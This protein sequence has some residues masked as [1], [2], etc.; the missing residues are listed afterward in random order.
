MR[1]IALT[2]SAFGPY[3][4]QT[5]LDL[6]QLGTGG[7][8]LIT[9]DT[10]AGK[11][12]L[13]DAITFGLYGE[14][15]GENRKPEMLR[16]QYADPATP[17][18]VELTFLCRDK[19]Y[20]VRRN[21]EYQRPAKRGGGVTLQ[22][23]EAQL[24]L[25]DGSVI[26]RGRDVNTKIE[27]ILGLDRDQFSRIA[28]IAQGDFRKL[29]FADTP[30]RQKIFRQLF[31]TGH[32]E[33]L[34]RRIGEEARSLRTACS[35]ARL[36]VNQYIAGLRCPEDS[37]LADT[38]A[39]AQ[40]GQL[41][42]ADTLALA[43]RLLA[44]DTQQKAVLDAKAS[45]LAQKLTQC[46]VQLGQAQETEKMQASLAKALTQQETLAP[47]LAQLE[48]DWLAQNSPAMQ[49]R[50]ETLEKEIHTLE[51]A[52]PQYQ[53][54][55]AQQESCRKLS[56]QVQALQ[57]EQIRREN[58]VQ[59]AQNALA[60]ARKALETLQDADTMLAGLEAKRTALQGQI[61]ALHD[62]QTLL[63]Q[64]K[65][66]HTETLAAQSA[67]VQA[68]Q[69]LAQALEQEK[70]L[71]KAIADEKAALAPLADSIEKREQIR[72]QG[73]EQSDRCRALTQAVEEQLACKA[74]RQT[75]QQA[76]TAYCDAAHI[77]A[78]REQTFQALQKAF[79]DE[80]AGILAQSLI[81]GV[82]CPVCGSIHHPQLAALTQG[83][84]TRDAVDA[85]RQQADQAQRLAQ[86]AS[87]EANR[88]KTLVEVRETALLQQ[89]AQL[90]HWD[91]PLEQA[92]A[93]LSAARTEAEKALAALRESYRCQDQIVQEKSRREEALAQQEQTLEALQPQLETL[94]SQCTQALTQYTAA[95][96]REEHLVT[97][98]AKQAPLLLG[99]DTQGDAAV[100]LQALLLNYSQ[101]DAA[102]QAQQAQQHQR[103]ER[104][105]LLRQTLPQQEQALT[106]AQTGLQAGAQQLA[107][108]TASLA[109]QTAQAESMQKALPLAGRPEAEAQLAAFRTQRDAQIQQRQT[110]LQQREQ[111][112]AQ[113][114][115]LDGQIQHLQQ[116]LK[117]APAVDIEAIT[118]QQADWQQQ[119]NAVEA[120]ARTVYA[121]AEAN[122][123]AR[124]QMAT[125]AEEL[126]QLEQRYT[127]VNALDE[128]TAG[129]ISGKGKVMLETYVQMTY[130]DRILQRANL[131]FMMMSSGQYELVRCRQAENNRNQS[132]L[133]L[134]VIDHY[135]GTRRS[136]KTL[137]GGESF[138]ASLSLA[139]GLSDEIQHTAGGVKLDTMFVDEGFG[140]LDEET[141]RQA[142]QA[143]AK[144]TEGDRL[145]GIISHVPELKEKI[146]KQIVVTKD[147]SGG[148]RVQ[149]RA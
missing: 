90:L 27:E 61:T 85:A 44:A 91:G 19:T 38:L 63:Q 133:D 54:L 41:P 105:T 145:V 58:V 67:Q 140:S 124:D 121:R 51:N 83:A 132:G 1:P 40:A 12:T 84:P 32:Y 72:A 16:S 46:S 21:P 113:K 71:R 123:T 31:K 128:T 101:Q 108:D 103:A 93:I 3:A 64:Q 143:L 86:Q 141:L 24:T 112:L 135:N 88:Q 146:E 122:R 59:K 6:T 49:S 11:T 80:Q 2:L 147:K 15:S 78:D 25:P 68:D 102:L 13:F 73:R 142:V 69:N 4:G 28:M 29:L 99:K 34:Q 47:R 95:Q 137:S 106:Q 65:A 136:V 97:M 10:G 100:Q 127:W 35:E 7:L 30:E 62:L 107:S 92:E 77:A 43:D 138:Q 18:F 56:G 37:P 94:R 114:A 120:A 55:E 22:K 60:D 75:L 33:T 130:F 117:Q 131:R 82:P 39:Q 45:E 144:L 79:L 50:Q 87:E 52:L 111:L 57:A 96:G 8:Y 129:K 9:G 139:L 23:A 17:T 26:T 134:D 70:A 110:M 5:Q 125:R 148:S 104:H 74:L 98:F 126:E 81:D 48:N 20:T 42:F 119:A 115:A 118:A 14:A 149:I 89:L 53:A 76:Q 66:A 109:A 116:A 36:S